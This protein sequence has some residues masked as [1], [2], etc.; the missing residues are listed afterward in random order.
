MTNILVVDDA[1]Q[2]ADFIA[3][4][5]KKHGDADWRVDTAYGIKKALES[6][7]QPVDVLV[8]S[9][10]LSGGDVFS[11]HEALQQRWPCM[12]TILFTEKLHPRQAQRTI[13][14]PGIVDCIFCSESKEAG[15]AAV[16]QAVQ[17]CMDAPYALGQSP[18]Q[19]LT[20]RRH[21]LNHEYGQASTAIQQM[22]AVSTSRERID[23]YHRLL[24]LYTQAVE[25]DVQLIYQERRMPPLFLDDE[26]WAHTIHVFAMLFANLSS[27]PPEILPRNSMLIAQVEQFARSHLADDLSLGRMAEVTG[28]STSNLSKVFKQMTGVGYNDYITQLRML[29]AAHCLRSNPR[30]A[31]GEIASSAGFNSTSYFIRVFREHFGITPAE[32]RKGC[33]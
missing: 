9:M 3:E 23:L 16:Q 12:K 27:T 26:G 32:Y 28:R 19:W 31:L 15:F 21:V 24:L 2:G 7:S 1:P 5:L 6:R 10:L 13:R 30:I 8:S 33:K 18:R 25:T 29:Q 17:T 14:T 20:I 11:L 22:K 4:Y